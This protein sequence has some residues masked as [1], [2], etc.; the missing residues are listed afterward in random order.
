MAIQAITIEDQRY[1]QHVRSVDFIKRYIF[2]GSCLVSVTAMSRAVT[3]ASDL[4]LVH[5]EDITPH[6]VET[7]KQWRERFLEKADAVRDLGLSDRFIRMWEYYLCYCEG[8]FAERYIGD[9][10]AV[11]HKPL[12]REAVPLPAMERESPG[13]AAES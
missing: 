7:L 1:A 8:A 2:P 11:F 6:Y 10:Q 3:H 4:R 9:V 12:Y 5:L 13:T